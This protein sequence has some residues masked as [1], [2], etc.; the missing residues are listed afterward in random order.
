M[1]EILDDNT[2]DAADYWQIIFDGQLDG[3]TAPQSDDF[4]IDVVG[5]ST[6]T[7]YQGDGTGWTV[8]TPAEDDI[9]FS[10][11]ISDSPT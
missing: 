7:V 1:V 2:D 8:V 11:Q 9:V 3:G 10:N 6:I 5:H 4:R